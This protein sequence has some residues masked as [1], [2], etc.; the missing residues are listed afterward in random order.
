MTAGR[1]SLVVG[2]VCVVGRPVAAAE[3]FQLGARALPAGDSASPD[4]PVL[5]VGY[6]PRAQSRLGLDVAIATTRTE[7]RTR[8]LG[9]AALVG[10]DNAVSR[11][12]LAGELGSTAI[13]LSLAWSLDAWALRRLGPRGVLELALVLG[14]RTAFSTERT[15]LLDPYRTD[16]VPFGAGGTYLGGEAEARLGLAAAWDLTLRL[17]LHAYL[18][19]FADLVGSREASDV[20]ADYLHEGA[21]WQTSLEAALE[22]RLGATTRL[23][24]AAYGETIGPHDDTAKQLWLARLELGPGFAAGA[25]AILPFVDFDAGHGPS[26]LVNRTELRTTVGVKLYA[27]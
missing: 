8:R 20:L 24:A 23:R 12:P 11:S 2:L 5:G 6:G 10:F 21:E 26:L 18:N 27:H 16:D 1:M 3:W 22:R 7:T 4:A 17:G 25:F 14:R 13:E 19:A 9:F 15:V